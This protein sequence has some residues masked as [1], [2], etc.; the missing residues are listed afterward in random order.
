MKLLPLLLLLLLL[1]AAVE[2]ATAWQLQTAALSRRWQGKSAATQ[3]TLSDDVAGS[4]STGTSASTDTGPTTS[5]SSPPATGGGGSA[6][7]YQQPE[8]KAVAYSEAA[9]LNVK[10]PV[11]ILVSPYLDQN[12]GSVSRAMLNFGLHELRVVDPRC[13]ILSD[14]ARALAAGSVEILENAKVYATCEECLADLQRVF[15]TTVRPRRT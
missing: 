10:M 8:T 13:D 2:V 4:S 14:N 6:F 15:A 3:M 1:V 9:A 12:V 7:R 5:S 11:I